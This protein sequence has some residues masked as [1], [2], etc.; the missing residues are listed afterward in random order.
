VDDAEDPADR[1]STPL[2]GPELPAVSANPTLDELLELATRQELRWPGS[3]SVVGECLDTHN[4]NLPGR[5][6]VR[7]R[8]RDGE[9]MTGW[10]PVMADVR[11]R[12]GDKLLLDKPDNWP[13]PV[14]VGAIA[15]LERPE[16]RSERDPSD[17][18]APGLQLEPGQAI[19]IAGPTGEALLELSST[20]EGIRIGLL[21]NEVELDAAGCL[22]FG[23]DRIELRAREGGVDVRTEGDVVVRGKTIRLN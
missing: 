12:V 3:G 11:I 16:R 15:G 9:A 2:P 5:V 21:S 20:S 7:A 18:G 17:A 6:L 10:L 14:V 22:R 23:A 4:P 13:E 8:D 19:V 1:E